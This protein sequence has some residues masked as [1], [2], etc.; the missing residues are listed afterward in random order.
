VSRTQI[1][2]TYILIDLAIVG[3]VVW[4][5]FQHIPARTFFLPVIVLFVVS[6]IWLIWA[7]IRSMPG[8]K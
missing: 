7:T 2:I 6:G 5:Y 4:C 3:I 1:F 8:Q